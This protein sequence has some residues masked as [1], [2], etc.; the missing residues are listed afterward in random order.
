MKFLINPLIWRASG[1]IS[2]FMG[3]LAL[4]ACF[5]L[6]ISTR[7]TVPVSS[8][9][10][11]DGLTNFVAFGNQLSYSLS[12]INGNVGVSQGGLLNLMAPATIDGDV[13]LN[14]LAMLIHMG[15][16]TGSIF[17]NQDL[18]PIQN[19]V[20]SASRTLAALPPDQTITENQTTGLSFDVPAGEV[21]VVNLIGGLNL[22]NEN[23]TL[24]GGGSL[25]LNIQGTFSLAGSAGIL[26]DPA[27]IYL[28]YLGTS[29]VSADVAST[30]NGLFFNADAD[31]RLG[32][33]VNGGLFSGSG[34]V[35]L[36]SGAIVNPV[37]EP[38]ELI[39][40]ALA[41][42]LFHLAR[43]RICSLKI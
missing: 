29:P 35:T 32:G 10:S 38:K 11:L 37:P 21:H 17:S 36:D 2:A 30:V 5:S 43:R 9:P 7:A 20:I 26:G 12:T 24:T 28:N 34:T 23:I 3:R 33:E 40:P 18:T 39:F 15:V 19:T 27:N 22:N 4:L 14:T 1:W 31:A 16:I 25:V 6:A 41:G 13:Y 42:L 8:L